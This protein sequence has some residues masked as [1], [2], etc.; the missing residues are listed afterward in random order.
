MSCKV[1]S[2]VNQKGGVA[3]STSTLNLGVEL[4]KQGKKVLLLDMDAQASLTMALGYQKPDDIEL[5]ISSVMQ[6][7][8][9][10]NPHDAKAA[11]L[12]HH[13][14]ID[15]LPSNIELSGL[16]VRLINAIGGERILKTYIHE[17][18]KDYDYILIDCMPSLGMLTINALAA[19]DSV[20]IPT[21]PHFLSAKG[22]ELLLRSVSKVKRQINTY[23]FQCY[24]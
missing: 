4:A 3:K 19:A 23:S 20:I 14:G 24:R 21:Q 6:G 13:E 11:I 10:D 9:D 15:L 1:I 5:N 22:L 8:M 12:H 7:I 17:V 18:K 16:E 2:L